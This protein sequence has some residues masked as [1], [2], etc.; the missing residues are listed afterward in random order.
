MGG[1]ATG[2]LGEGWAAQAHRQLVKFGYQSR[3][4]SPLEGP[5]ANWSDLGCVLKF[6]Y[7]ENPPTTTPPPRAPVR[8][9][10]ALPSSQPATGRSPQAGASP[11]AR[12]GWLAG[13]HRSNAAPARAPLPHTEHAG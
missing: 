13:T 7:V 1:E 10:P 6:T 3:G 8:P 12:L 9:S 5:T 11:P 4:G 2:D